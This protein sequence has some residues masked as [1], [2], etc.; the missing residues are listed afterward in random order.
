MML[1]VAEDVMVPGDMG[2]L[3]LELPLQLHIAAEAATAK[4]APPS[5]E[6]RIVVT[7]Q[8][9]RDWMHRDRTQARVHHK[10]PWSRRIGTAGLSRYV[11]RTEERMRIAQK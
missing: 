8:V 5:N 10:S 6:N 3:L 1:T 2:L 7:S 11:R 4:A 9:E